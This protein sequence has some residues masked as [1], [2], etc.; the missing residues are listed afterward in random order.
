MTDHAMNGI[1][2]T[3]PAARGGQ[4]PKPPRG[5]PKA[6]GLRATRSRNILRGAVKSNY[7]AQHS[8]NQPPVV[9]SVGQKVSTTLTDV[10]R[11]AHFAETG[12]DP[13]V[14]TDGQTVD[15][16]R[17]ALEAVCEQRGWQ[18]AK[19]IPTTAY[20]APRDTSSGLAWTLC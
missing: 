18:L 17:L 4:A 8:L 6:Q 3:L 13:R 5:A 19:S 2:A 9:H 12:H 7:I 15:N 16:Q 11:C 20:L 10:T 1:N 14:S